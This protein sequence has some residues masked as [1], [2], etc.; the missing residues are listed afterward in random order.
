MKKYHPVPPSKNPGTIYERGLFSKAD[1][2]VIAIFL[3]AL[4]VAVIS[5][6]SNCH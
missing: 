5:R 6:M 4:T 2:F 3:I 1:I